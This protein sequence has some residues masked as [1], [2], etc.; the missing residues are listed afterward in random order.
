[1][2]LTD[3]FSVFTHHSMPHFNNN[4]QPFTW[5]SFP[6][7]SFGLQGTNFGFWTVMQQKKGG[8]IA[9]GIVF[10]ADTDSLLKLLPEFIHEFK[11]PL[12][13]IADASNSV[14]RTMLFF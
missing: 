6:E 10:K 7:T 2:N 5:R 9:I 4:S 13:A 8:K 11:V 12:V 14:N 1:M 3:N